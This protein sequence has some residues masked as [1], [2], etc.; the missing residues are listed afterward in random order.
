MLHKLARGL[1]VAA[2]DSAERTKRA[3]GLLRRGGQ[4]SKSQEA[5]LE[6]ILD[7]SRVKQSH[8]LASKASF[9]LKRKGT[10]ALTCQKDRNTQSKM[11]L[12][13]EGHSSISPES[14]QIQRPA[15]ISA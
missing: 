14:Q 10:L 11:H 6:R 2:A 3:F 15:E 8:S 5:P 4:F 13:W 7:K 12:A 1:E 9:L